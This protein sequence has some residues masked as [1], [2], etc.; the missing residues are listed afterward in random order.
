MKLVLDIFLVLHLLAFA[1]IV[2]GVLAETK[3][4]KH[5][6]KVNPGILHGSWLALITG[7]VMAGVLPFAEPDETLNGTVL[8]VKGLALTAI[9]FIGY[10]FQKKDQTPKWVVPSVGLLAVIAV[11]TAVIGGVTY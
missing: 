7:L 11:S 6:A 9:F 5:G 1:T 10:T 2:G 8:A 3:N 4:F